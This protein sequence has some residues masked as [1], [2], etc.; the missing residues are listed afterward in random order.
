MSLYPNLRIF[1]ICSKF[2][3]YWNFICANEFYE[4]LT[5]GDDVCSHVLEE[6]NLEFEIERQNYQQ[7][8]KRLES[9]VKGYE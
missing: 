5:K 4:K 8:I 6:L 3:E 7:K 1:E 9:C 2:L